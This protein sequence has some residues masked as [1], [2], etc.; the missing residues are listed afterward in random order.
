M[1]TTPEIWQCPTHPGG[2]R[3]FFASSRDQLDRVSDLTAITNVLSA[4]ISLVGSLLVGGL[5]VNGGSRVFGRPPRTLSAV[6][7]AFLV[8][9]HLR[10]CLVLDADL[11]QQKHLR[12]RSHVP[13]EVFVLILYGLALALVVLHHSRRNDVHQGKALL[14]F[15]LLG[16]AA[17]AMNPSQGGNSLGSAVRW[18]PITVSIGLSI[19]AIAHTA[20][21]DVSVRELRA[22]TTSEA[23]NDTV[24]VTKEAFV[25]GKCDGDYDQRLSEH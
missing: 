14:A 19:S 2:S 6:T 1:G 10:V 7:M 9:R 12:L 20:M 23:W 3:R 24:Y 5:E 4:S 22:T 16:F 25:E 13:V 11:D 8:T 18:L 15:V 21:R 17:G